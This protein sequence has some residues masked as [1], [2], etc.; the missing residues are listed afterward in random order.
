M[1]SS[2]ATNSNSRKRAY[3]LRPM[4]KTTNVRNSMPNR[5]HINSSI[6]TRSTL[7]RQ[8]RQPVQRSVSNSTSNISY[9]KD[10]LSIELRDQ[11]YEN[12]DFADIES[13]ALQKLLAHLREYIQDRINSEDYDNAEKASGLAE[14]VKSQLSKPQNTDTSNTEKNSDTLSTERT[15]LKQFDDKWKEKFDQYDKT[16][17]EKLKELE[18]KQAQQ[19]QEFEKL[20]STE[21]PQRYRKPSDD[22]VKL[23]ALERSLAMSGQFDRARTIHAEAEKLALKEQKEL[24]KSLINDYRAAKETFV[25]KQKQEKEKFLSVRAANRSRMETK[26]KIELA[27][28]ENRNAVVQERSKSQ[29]NNSNKERNSG[30]DFHMCYPT[31]NTQNKTKSPDNLIPPLFAPNDPQ[32]VEEEERKLREKRKR[33]LEMQKKNAEATL[34]EYTVQPS[35]R[36]ENESKSEQQ[37]NGG[38]LDKLIVDNLD[39]FSNPQ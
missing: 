22:L 7:N 13:S 8:N 18:D 6:S 28:V 11:L 20:W 1:R 4:A 27:K 25:E 24:Q 31:M 19:L 39:Q 37:N 30:Q 38:A 17:N 9:L 2:L 35:P 3:I 14:L 33:Q 23:K 16:T 34:L 32:F 29:Q 12:P 21:K 26:K 15:A 5:T 36:D 10:A